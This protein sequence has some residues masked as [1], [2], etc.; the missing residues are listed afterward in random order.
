MNDGNVEV[1][2]VKY[3]RLNGSN[4]SKLLLCSR[5][6]NFVID[7]NMKSLYWAV[8]SYKV[9]Q[10]VE[11]HRDAQGVVVVVVVDSKCLNLKH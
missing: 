2:E 8:F 11:T 6:V 1:M 7:L 9:N 4:C 3:R 10:Y 5:G